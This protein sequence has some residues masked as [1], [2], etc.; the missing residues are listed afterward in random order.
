M[1]GR[2]LGR[3]GFAALLVGA[4]ASGC[5]DA[6]PESP[7][8]PPI[9][10]VKGA[11]RVDVVYPLAGAL[12]SVRDSNMIYGNVGNGEV[13]LAINGRPVKVE[14]NGA[15]LAF[16]PVPAE[17]GDTLATYDLVARLGAEVV[18]G[19]HTVRLPP[20]SGSPSEE[21]VAIDAANAAPR[22]VWWALDGEPIPVRVRATPGADVRLTLPDGRTKSLTERPS[23]Q[24][25][26][27]GR[28]ITGRPGRDSVGSGVYEG[29]FAAGSPLGR[30]SR[31]A[32]PPLAP[33]SG[34]VDSARRPVIEVRSGDGIVRARLP[35]D[36]WIL[37]GPGPM[38]ELQQAVRLSGGEGA[39]IGRTGPQGA[40][41]WLWADGVRARV[42]G[43]RNR[44]VRVGLDQQ[45]DAWIDV[46]DLKWLPDATLDRPVA[47]GSVGLNERPDRLEARIAVPAP[48]PYA[49]RIRERR[50]SLVLYG[51]YSATHSIAV[52]RE[53][54][55]LRTAGWEQLARDRYVLHLD[56]TREPWGY[57][58][59]YERGVLML[60]IR[61]PPQIEARRPL[62]GRTI[63]VDAG[64][65]PGGATGPTRLYEADANLEI[66]LR[67]Q[68][69]L[70]RADARV[71]LTRPDRLPVSLGDRIRRA[72]GEDAEVI[73]S[74]HNNALADGRNPSGE[75]GTSVY[76]FQ[77]FAIDLARALRTGLVQAL[78]LPDQG[79]TQAN[80]AITRSTWIP[81][82]LIEGAFI[83]IPAQEA[84]LQN[85]EF[86]DAY[87]AGVVEGIRAYF[88]E[89]AQ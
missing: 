21:R 78:G 20:G 10:L 40:L 30:G 50:V 26:L 11:L 69:L 89:R 8:P 15:F 43:R 73:A 58:A 32:R 9:P 81:A 35:L 25:R 53:G 47:V 2:A 56:L 85:S 13:R 46:E 34:A 28:W 29:S 72:H 79:I 42:T 71:V 62:A 18:R 57:R 82:V 83:T 84:A 23:N 61:R 60:S 7:G 67:V 1:L 86:L 41:A 77:P 48:V 59:R 5:R 16:L 87:A 76:Y 65:P 55:L 45:S 88:R 44:S 36:L 68:R 27:R 22:G 49:V 75:L 70:E 3:A 38:V 4:A 66:A 33:E 31:T 39:T 37:D 51:A 12:I 17:P 64:H 54:D 80:H 63:V 19:R 52:G 74:I 24:P 6:A 14:A